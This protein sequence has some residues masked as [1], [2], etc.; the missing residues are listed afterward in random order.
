M[1]ALL[2]DVGKIH[3]EF[4]PILRKPGRLT[5]EEFDVMKSH[6][7]RGAVL[8]SKVSHFE[9]LVPM[10]EAHHESWDGRGYP[11]QIAGQDIPRGA[12]IIALADTIDAMTTS[13]PYRAAMTDEDVRLEI[14]R[15]AG[16]QFDPIIVRKLLV[17]ANWREVCREIDVAVSEHPVSPEIERFLREISPVRA[18]Q[19]SS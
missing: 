13:R 6:S 14:E 1:A 15:E 5:A 4:A 9:D 10:I 3:E 18:G 8:V 11:N 12:R 2:H 7:A 16:R 17:D 19:Q